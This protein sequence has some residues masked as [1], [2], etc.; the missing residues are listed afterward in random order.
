MENLPIIFKRVE[1]ALG[2]LRELVSVR[3]FHGVKC[4]L[5]G[6]EVPCFSGIKGTSL[7]MALKCCCGVELMAQKE[8]GEACQSEGLEKQ[9]DFERDF[10]R[11]L[12][13]IHRLDYYKLELK[14]LDGLKE[15]IKGIGQ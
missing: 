4:R 12:I 9:R 3:Q 2:E 1:N 13:K 8:A 14:K 11:E 6:K 10:A 15:V 5:C 7:V